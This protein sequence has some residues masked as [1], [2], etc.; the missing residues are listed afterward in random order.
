MNLSPVIIL[1]HHG[2]TILSPWE[3]FHFYS[4]LH[5]GHYLQAVAVEEIKSELLSKLIYKTIGRYIT[6]KDAH[7]F[8]HVYIDMKSYGKNKRT[9]NMYNRFTP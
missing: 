8:R 2:T 5:S 6:L 4:S 1:Y 9:H 3:I 7:A